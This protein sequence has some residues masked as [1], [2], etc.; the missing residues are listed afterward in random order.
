MPLKSL[1]LA[2]SNPDKLAEIRAI[3]EGCARLVPV[4]DIVPGW[5]CPEDMPTI[6]GNAIRKARAAAEASGLPA[7]AD[8]TGLFVSVLGGAPGVYTSRFSGTGCSYSDNIAKLLRVMN[9]ESDRT[10][11]F[12]TAVALCSPDGS[13]DLFGGEVAGEILREPRGTGGFGYDPVFLL[14]GPGLT[15]A[16][17]PAGVKNELS[18][19]ALAFSALRTHL[20][21]P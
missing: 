4:T 14:P 19:R 12:R 10:A 6:E 20:A 7:A 18:H 13:C 8:D 11:L 16:E 5:D 3:L 2:T 1:V 15:F 9:W 17:C 21:A